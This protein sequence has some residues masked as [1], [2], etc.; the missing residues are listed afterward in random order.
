MLR[1][2]GRLRRFG[3]LARA[4]PVARKRQARPAS[5]VF[6]T[7]TSYP[8]DWLFI[9]PGYRYA[10]HL[11]PSVDESEARVLTSITLQ[12]GGAVAQLGSRLDCIEEVGGSNPIGST[13]I[14]PRVYTHV[15]HCH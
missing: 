5:D 8:L 14:F 15:V 1:L 12:F 9:A 7:P 6:F 4:I 11:S 2:A 13:K 3:N 10:R